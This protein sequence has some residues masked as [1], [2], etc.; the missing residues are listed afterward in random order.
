MT[1]QNLIIPDTLKSNT[2]V[3]SL[4]KQSKYKTLSDKQINVLKGMLDIPLQLLD[5]K[6]KTVKVYNRYFYRFDYHGDVLQDSEIVYDV[7]DTN[8]KIQDLHAA[9]YDNEVYI[10]K[11]KHIKDV[12][13][14]FNVTNV[15]YFMD[16]YYNDYIELTKKLQ[17]NKFRSTKSKNN[18]IFLLNKM[19][20]GDVNT[21]EN[22]PNY[23]Y[24]HR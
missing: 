3:Q 11:Y 21:M 20:L 7:E 2:F 8:V 5:T 10:N 19:I 6:Y 9:Q 16:F 4:F 15:N 24:N 13:I 22:I 14:P 1:I 18:V 17:R 12:K 23:N